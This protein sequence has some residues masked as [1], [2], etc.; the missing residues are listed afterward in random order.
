MP[1]D[2]SRRLW[3]RPAILL[4]FLALMAA[5]ARAGHAPARLEALA[6]S[7]R[8]SGSWTAGVLLAGY[9][10]RPLTLIPIAPLWIVSGALLGWGTGASVSLAGTCLGA[11]VAFALARRLG[12]DFVERRFPRLG[13]LGRVDASWGL[14][15]VIALQ[16]MPVVPHDLVNGMAGV[17]RIPYRS[18]FLGTLLGCLPLIVLYTYAGS[19]VLEVDSSRFWIAAGILAALTIG[20]LVWNRR[21]A[22]KGS[23]KPETQPSEEGR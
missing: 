16:L 22:R 7:A 17:S 21:I 4:G 1:P 12:R 5:L 18:F 15:A 19:A 8:D 20:M 23:G 13:R 14:R 3:I 9:V 2:G 6:G 10:L 11:A